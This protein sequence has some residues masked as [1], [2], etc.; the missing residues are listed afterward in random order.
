[1][2]KYVISAVA[3]ITHEKLYSRYSDV[4]VRKYANTVYTHAT[5]NTHEPRI[6][7]TVGT[8][9]L[10]MPRDAAMVQSMNADMA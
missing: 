1:M 3:V 2:T 5:R 7:I 8:T 9:A 6:T 10:P 4:I